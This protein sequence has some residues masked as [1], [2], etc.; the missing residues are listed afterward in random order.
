ML[1]HFTT[2]RFEPLPV[3]TTTFTHCPNNPPLRTL[4]STAHRRPAHLEPPVIAHFHGGSLSGADWPP[5]ILHDGTV[6]SAFQV[7]GA[8]VLDIFE[9]P[10]LAGPSTGGELASHVLHMSG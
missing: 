10:D 9:F 6:L 8:C 2:G 3:A 5:H 7:G 1:N 4:S